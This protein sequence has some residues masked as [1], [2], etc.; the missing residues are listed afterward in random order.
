VTQKTHSNIVIELFQFT[1]L[2][3]VNLVLK[4]HIESV[5]LNNLRSR[6]NPALLPTQF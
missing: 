3:K 1:K 5:K 2:I 4:L 6:E